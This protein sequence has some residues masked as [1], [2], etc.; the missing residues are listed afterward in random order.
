MGKTTLLEQF[1]SGY[2]PA[3]HAINFEKDLRLAPLFETNLDPRHLIKELEFVLD[4][5]IDPENDLLIFD[6]I[7]ACPRALTSLKYFAE[8]MPQL[9]LAAA[10]SLLG[11][12]LGPVSFPVGKVDILTLYPMSFEEFLMAL[13]DQR[14]LDLLRELKLRDHLFEMAHQHLFE[15]LKH[16]LSSGAFPKWW[17]FF[18]EKKRACIPLFSRYA[19][20]RIR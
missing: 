10:G 9:A 7:Q 20:S 12:Y 3:V 8:G 14:S 16:F 2:F 13:E 5:A 6:E 4:R 11:V 15:Q 17:R 18:A 19:R 1:G